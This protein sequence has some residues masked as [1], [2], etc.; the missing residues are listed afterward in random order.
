VTTVSTIIAVY[1]C[2]DYIAESVASALGQTFRDQEIIVIDG[3]ST[4]G[5]VER[6]QPYR[7]RIK[8]MVQT[9]KGVANARNEAIKASRGE[10]IAI[11]DADDKWLPHKLE[12]QMEYLRSHP[13][14]GLL[15]ADEYYYDA[16]GRYRGRWFQCRIPVYTGHVFGRLF[17]NN[18]VGTL[19][20]VIRRTCFDRVGFFDESLFYAEDTEMWL[21]IAYEYP[22]GYLD[23]PLAVCHVRPESRSRAFEKHYQVKTRILNS[24]LDKYPDYFRARPEIRKRGLSNHHYKFGYQYFAIGRMSEAREEFREAL[25]QRPFHGRCLVYWLSCYLPSS[26]LTGVRTA[27]RM[28]GGMSAL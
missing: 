11:L 9:G 8:F 14:I 26:V 21:R 4:D 10:F 13:E 18:F 19:T 12:V 27:K 16:Q 28:I 3:G 17:E 1:N 23:Q 22:I 24:L 2:A 5:T 7:D 6:L 25:R 20:A 15:F